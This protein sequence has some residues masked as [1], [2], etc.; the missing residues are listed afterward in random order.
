MN[1]IKAQLDQEEEM[2]DELYVSGK[3]KSVKN[4]ERAKKDLLESVRDTRLKTK[5]IS[6]RVNEADL[7]RIKILALREGIP[8]QTLINSVIHK[9]TTMAG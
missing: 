9:Y 3:L 6:L 5:Q 1:K 7:R 2:W 4:L 8:Y